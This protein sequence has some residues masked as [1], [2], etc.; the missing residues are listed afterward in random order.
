MDNRFE[1]VK[2]LWF[3]CKRLLMNEEV[4]YE[5]TCKMVDTFLE[6]GFNYFDTVHGYLG[7]KSG[8]L[9]EVDKAT[10]SRNTYL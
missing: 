9:R 2:E 7:G 4:D 1:D 5:E 6:N 8:A 10:Q 3:G